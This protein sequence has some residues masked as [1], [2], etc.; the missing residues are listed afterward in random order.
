MALLDNNAQVADHSADSAARALEALVLKQMLQ[1]SGMFKGSSDSAGSS[2]RSDLFA[3]ALADAVANAG[4]I[5]L[6]AQLTAGLPA[7]PTPSPRPVPH[8]VPLAPPTTTSTLSGVDL[9]RLVA[10]GGRITSGFGTRI[11]PIHH[12]PS[13]H[14]GVDVSAVE[15]TPIL[16]AASGVVRRAGV[17]GGYGNAIEVDHGEGLSTLYGHASQLLV[18]EGERVEKGQAIARV[19]STGRST[20]P[21][22]HFEV[23]V[24]GSPTDPVQ[25]LKA[26]PARAD[27]RVER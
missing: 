12:Q 7:A 14:P 19:G 11:D 16:A 18:Q 24:G 26:S 13:M 8:L 3:D 21:H 17:R 10:G 9:S 27:T 6:G 25:A 22:L 1:A 2:I 15:G 20:G 5:G 4:G 23:R